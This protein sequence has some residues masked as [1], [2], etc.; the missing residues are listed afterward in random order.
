M[1]AN[2]PQE[3]LA[4]PEIEAALA[5]AGEVVAAFQAACDQLRAAV[6]GARRTR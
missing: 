6:Q 2:P 1:T 5:R 4:T 3:Q